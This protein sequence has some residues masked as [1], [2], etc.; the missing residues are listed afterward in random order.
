MPNSWAKMS[1]TRLG[2]PR[3]FCS[4]Y[5]G[6]GA[7]PASTVAVLVISDKSKFTFSVDVLLVTVHPEVVEQ[8]V[9]QP[10]RVE[11]KV[12]EDTQTI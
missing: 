6:P 2:S 9:E 11:R 10:V 12:F 1:D 3:G 5:A 8:L 7:S 4:W